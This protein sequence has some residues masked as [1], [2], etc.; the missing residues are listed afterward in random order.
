M[1]GT[2]YK[3]AM[4]MVP[5]VDKESTEDTGQQKQKEGYKIRNIIRIRQ[6]PQ[7]RDKLPIK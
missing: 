1:Y 7:T 5:V 2:T 6:W 3:L 4:A